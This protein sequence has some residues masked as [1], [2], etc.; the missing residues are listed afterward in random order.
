MR[1]TV[2]AISTRGSPKF[3]KPFG[4]GYPRLNQIQII[5][6]TMIPQAIL[7]PPVSWYGSPIAFEARVDQFVKYGF[8]GKY[9]HGK[10]TDVGLGKGY[11]EIKM[12]WTDSPCWTVCW[13]DGN[14]FIEALRA[15][16][17][18]EF[19]LAQHPWLEN[20]CLFA[21]IV[22]PGSTY[23]EVNDI[24][25]TAM[26]NH[27]SVWYGKKCIEPIGESKSDYE[28][29][30]MIADKLGMLETY[31]EGKTEE[32]W[33]RLGYEQSGIA[34][35]VSWETLKEKGYFIVPTHPEW[36]KDPP[37]MRGFYEDPDNPANRLETPTGKLEFYSQALADK[38]PDDNERPPVPHWIPCGE[39]HQESLLCDRA[40]KY[41]LL[42]IT[43]HPRWRVHANHDDISWL[44][45]TPTCKVSG[46][47]GY[48]YEPIWIHPVDAARRGI[49]NG[50]ILSMY[51]E[52]GAVLGGAIVTE[53]ITPG[54]VYQDHGARHDPIVVAGKG[55]YGIDRAG[56]NNLI[57]PLGTTSKNATGMATSGYLVEVEKANMD[58]L[59]V[60]YPEAFKRPIDPGAGPTRE[61][62]I[63]S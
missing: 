3:A 42:L 49:R 25:C 1:T 35:L 55:E 46:P 34:D 4:V 14:K 24:Y 22:L 59:M 62:W 29:V 26:E 18:V 52:R 38:W 54:A 10:D 2:V 40:K 15:P 63:R 47:D 23:F 60:K 50:D 33:L 56:S 11:P 44:R 37:G 48:Q 13:N 43:N 17:K 9:E 53:R 6:K 41:P 51:N 36:K 28:I 39:T 30:C 57:S 20:D 7:N 61:G 19:V 32:E 45:E 58:E 31:T 16:N 21:D 12:I 27:A 8:P 5:A